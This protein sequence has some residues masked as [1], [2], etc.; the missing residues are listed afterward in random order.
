MICTNIIRDYIKINVQNTVQWL[1]SWG[2]GNYCS[3]TPAPSALGAE[4]WRMRETVNFS[5]TLGNQRGIIALLPSLCFYQPLF[6]SPPSLPPF[7][8]F[9]LGLEE[10]NYLSQCTNIMLSPKLDPP[11]S[12]SCWC[13]IP[14][15]WL[16]NLFITLLSI[17][18][19]L[20]LVQTF[21]VYII[22]FSGL[23]GLWTHTW[24]F[25]SFSIS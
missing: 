14:C 5:H 12:L 9:Y 10:L 13:S 23:W 18:A 11:R 6:K 15:H 8:I 3:P 21:L 19:D 1:S 4:S 24:Y 25:V 17:S 7:Q 22:S 20:T 2:C 16:H